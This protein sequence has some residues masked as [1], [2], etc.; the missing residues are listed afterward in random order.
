[1]IKT[2]KK[3]FTYK[4]WRYRSFRWQDFSGV[5]FVHIKYRFYYDYKV[6]ISY[7]IS[8]YISNNESYPDHKEDEYAKWLTQCSEIQLNLVMC[9]LFF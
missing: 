3:K 9:R 5:T 6:N 8:L 7:Y 4:T 2:H 1:M